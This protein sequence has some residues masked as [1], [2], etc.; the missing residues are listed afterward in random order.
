MAAAKKSCEDLPIDKRISKAERKIKSFFKNIDDEKKRFI[1]EP[2]HQLAV[3]Q[4]L[5]ERLSEEL[6]N[7]DVI[8]WFEQGSQKIKRENPALKSY[9]ATIK[10]Y[11][12][13]FKQLLDLLPNTEA[14][15]AGQALMMFAAKAPAGSKK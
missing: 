3:T 6:E 7:G 4:I 11:T 1:A 2:I 5:L 13:L 12:A 10:S 14:E 8:E 15:K 9:N